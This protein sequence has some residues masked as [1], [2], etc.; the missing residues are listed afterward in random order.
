L[1]ALCRLEFDPYKR[2]FLAILS[3]SSRTMGMTLGARE[4][5]GNGKVR[6]WEPQPAHD[7]GWRMRMKKGEHKIRMTE[8]GMT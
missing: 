6:E 1:L 8:Q 5:T 2:P 4:R 7:R 3:A